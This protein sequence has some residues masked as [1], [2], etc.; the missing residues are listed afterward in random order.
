MEELDGFV[1]E[2]LGAQ[3][4]GAEDLVVE[5]HAERHRVLYYL[6][7]QCLLLAQSGQ[8]S[9]VFD[10]TVFDCLPQPSLL[11]LEQP[12]KLEIV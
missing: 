11:V 9:H 7:V 2:Y 1:L 12:D 5:V 3:E 8:P 10:E 6:L 4:A